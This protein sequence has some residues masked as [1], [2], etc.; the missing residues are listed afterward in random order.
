MPKPMDRPDR[1][2]SP[3]ERDPEFAGLPVI[4]VG[5]G[6]SLKGFDFESIRGIPTIAVNSAF[7]VV[8]WAKY[9][10]FADHRWFMWNEAKLKSSQHLPV[11]VG[12]SL[13]P[14]WYMPRLKRVVR[15]K[16]DGLCHER[17]HLA[18]IDSG[19]LAVNMAFHLGASRIILLGY[20]S[21][22]GPR[23]EA[24]GRITPNA[25]HFHD[26]HQVPANNMYYTDRYG[27]RLVSMC[28]RLRDIGV[29]VVRSTPPGRPEIPYVPLP[30]A[31]TAPLPPV[32]GEVI[33]QFIP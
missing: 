17:T 27:P 15:M 32:E 3:I 5:G 25:S 20:D 1:V 29:P 7:E 24:D 13:F 18:G 6:P 16:D 9:L 19:N 23:V 30:E 33:T 26:N 28:Q 4:C 10:F 2:L 31:L 22:F 14:P 8:P 11:T 21:G 12:K